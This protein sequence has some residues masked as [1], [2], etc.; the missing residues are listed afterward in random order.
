MMRPTDTTNNAQVLVKNLLSKSIKR[1]PTLRPVQ[2]GIQLY[3][4]MF[5]ERW[6]AASRMPCTLGFAGMPWLS[7]PYFMVAEILPYGSVGHNHP[8][9]WTRQSGHHVFKGRH[10]RAFEWRR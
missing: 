9:Q 8:S 3:S 2:S 4:A 5:D 7:F 10:W 6:R 1:S